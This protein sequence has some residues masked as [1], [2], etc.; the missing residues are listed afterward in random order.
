[1]VCSINPCSH[2]N[3]K[4]K[5]LKVKPSI[6]ATFILKSTFLYL[7]HLIHT[8]I[9]FHLASTSDLHPSLFLNLFS[10]GVILSH[11]S[12]EIS[13]I[14]VPHSP[15]CHLSWKQDNHCMGWCTHYPVA[16][17]Q[18]LLPSWRPPLLSPCWFTGKDTLVQTWCSKELNHNQNTLNQQGFML[19]WTLKSE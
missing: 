6:E 16:S 12:S 3:S 2:S 4:M 15:Q 9:L 7:V 11:W 13:V 14:C 10:V 19:C 18:R 5:E 8:A 17:E 1:M